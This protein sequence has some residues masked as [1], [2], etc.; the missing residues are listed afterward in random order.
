MGVILPLDY[1]RKGVGVR[2]YK[3]SHDSDC[4]RGVP[5]HLA[6][7]NRNLSRPLVPNLGISHEH[8]YNQLRSPNTTIVG[9]Y[10][11]AYQICVNFTKSGRALRRYT[12]AWLYPSPLGSVDGFTSTPIDHRPFLVIVGS[13]EAT[14][15]KSTF[16]SKYDPWFAY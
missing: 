9:F 11:P 8:D 2:N 5:R 14:Y 12:T 7:R 4:K 13:N 16:E 10:S 6:T 1:D 3:C 15:N